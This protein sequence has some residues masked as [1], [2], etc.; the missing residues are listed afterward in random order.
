MVF[1]Q[2]HDGCYECFGAAEDILLF[3]YTCWLTNI[4]FNGY[5]LGA[6][7]THIHIH[8][9]YIY[10]FWHYTSTMLEVLQWKTQYLMQSF[11][12][13]T[14]YRSIYFFNLITLVWNVDWQKPFLLLHSLVFV[15]STSFFCFHQA[16]TYSIY[17]H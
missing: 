14:M 16:T 2:H 1:L 11:S 7:C 12:R 8:S 5:K 15:S 10:I 9:Y 6:S 3:W 13:L 4:V 17:Q